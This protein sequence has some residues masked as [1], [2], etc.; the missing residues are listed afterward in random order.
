[1]HAEDSSK[2]DID[3]QSFSVSKFKHAELHSLA[4]SLDK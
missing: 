3:R 2:A 4:S 1:M